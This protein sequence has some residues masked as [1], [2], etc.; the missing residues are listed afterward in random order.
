LL[1]NGL[2]LIAGGYD[3]AN[4]AVSATDLYDPGTKTFAAGASMTGPRVYA[5]AVAMQ[6]GQVLITGGYDANSLPL[7]SAELYDPVGG[8]TF[9]ATGTMNVARFAATATNLPNGK[10]LVAGG[11]GP[12]STPLA[13]AELYD[14][15][16][17]QFQPIGASVCSISSGDSVS[18]NGAGTCVIDADQA[19]NAYYNPATRAKQSIQVVKLDQTIQFT[20]PAP[21]GATVGGP[22]YNVTAQASSN[23]PVTL[24]IDG[25]AS[26]VCS[27]SGSTVSFKAAG[28]C[29]V[30][31]DQAGDATYNAAPRKQQL[32]QVGKADQTIQF[33]TTA[34]VGATVGGPTY[35][36]A[37]QASSNLPVTLTID[38]AASNV[39]SISGGF[40]SFKG[41]GQCI[42]DADQAGDAT[43][44]AA[45][46]KQQSFPVVT[47]GTAKLVFTVQPASTQAGVATSAQ[48][49]VEDASSKV[50]TSD[51]TTQIT[52]SINLCGGTTLGVATVQQGVASFPNVKLSTPGMNLTLHATSNPA[53]T[54]TD[55]M[56]FNV[57]ANPI[58]RDGFET[59]V[60]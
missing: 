48:V 52:I 44:N 32:F 43:Y 56:P 23:L 38:G 36:V 6:N 24:T 30:D 50:I 5:A 2:A 60:P 47:V 26:S 8:G 28:Q 4:A 59:C 49:S 54:S 55:S 41:A 7:A 11:Y 18:F 27:I 16:T 29:I 12:G 19:G 9:T 33:T 58:F 37:A 53:L 42:I 39:C 31:A 35:N 15:A 21:V 10:V 46:Q 45:P 40:V 13:S 20:T 25:A 57:T 34:P 51:N 17:G 22:T 14:P 1:A 3:A